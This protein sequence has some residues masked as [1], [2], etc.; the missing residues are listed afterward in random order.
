M[1]GRSCPPGSCGNGVVVIE[2]AARAHFE[3]DVL[4]LVFW[5]HGLEGVKEEVRLGHFVGGCGRVWKPR[6]R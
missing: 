5:E 3:C 1:G 6:R 4:P 2:Y